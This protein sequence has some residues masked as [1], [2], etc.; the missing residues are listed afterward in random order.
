MH[1]ELSRL[2]S[3]E[4]FWTGSSMQP[5]T[6]VSW[7]GSRRSFLPYWWSGAEECVV[8]QS[9]M[10]WWA[11]DGRHW[12]VFCMDVGFSKSTVPLWAVED[13]ESCWAWGRTVRRWTALTFAVL[14]LKTFLT[15]KAFLAPVFIGQTVWT[16]EAGLVSQ[17]CANNWLFLTL[18]LLNL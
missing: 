4:M 15:P 5:S 18:M 9:L 8:C 2:F 14:H 6:V 13:D 3:K 1:F 12:S 7:T 11:A 16:L 17:C 10:L